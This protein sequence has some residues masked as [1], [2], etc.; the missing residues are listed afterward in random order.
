MAV[1]FGATRNMNSEPMDEGEEYD[2]DND[3]PMPTGYLRVGYAF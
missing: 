2:D 3:D 1:A